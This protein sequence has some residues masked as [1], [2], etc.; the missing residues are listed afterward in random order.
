MTARP[1]G[2]LV[3]IRS[4]QAFGTLEFH[5][6]PRLDVYLNVGGEYDSRAAYV[7]S[8]GEGSGLRLAAS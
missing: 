7:N 2:T 4:Y 8:A 5:P 6:T 3:P 1:D